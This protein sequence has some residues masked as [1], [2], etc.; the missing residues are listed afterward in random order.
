MGNCFEKEDVIKFQ[1]IDKDGNP[2][3]FAT[4]EIE[5]LKYTADENGVVTMKTRRYEKYNKNK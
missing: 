2:R 5:G 1:I 3:T 4:L